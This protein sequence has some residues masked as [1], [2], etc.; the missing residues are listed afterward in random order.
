MM[1]RTTTTT[2]AAPHQAPAE[3]VLALTAKAW[4]IAPPSPAALV[5]RAPHGY[6][7][8]RVLRR[9]LQGA[10]APLPAPLLA[11]SW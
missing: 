3:R 2:T 9:A 7:R 8:Q 4:G 5:R 10:C 6:V 11:H 1:A